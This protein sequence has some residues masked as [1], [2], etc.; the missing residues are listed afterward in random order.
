M[1][2]IACVLALAVVSHGI[3]TVGDWNAWKEEQGKDYNNVDEDLY[4]FGVFQRNVEMIAELNERAQTPGSGLEGVFGLNPLSDLTEAEVR[5]YYLQCL[6]PQTK[7]RKKVHS[8]ELS[9]EIP[10][11]FD[12]RSKGAV[13]PDKDQGQCGS[14][15]AFATVG[16]VEG[17]NF[18]KK[19]GALPNL[20]EQDEVDCSKKQH[21]MGCNGGRVDWGLDYAI[22]AKGL[23]T[24]ASYPY[25]ARDGT[26]KHKPDTVG[27][28]VSKY[29]K[30]KT[31]NETDL[32]SAIA[33]VGPVGVA[34]CVTNAWANY[35]TGVFYDASC[36]SGEFDLSHA[37]LAVGYGT[38]SGKDYFIVKNS[39]GGKWGDGGYIKMARNRNNNCGISTDAYYPTDV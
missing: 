23:D 15:W 35:K 26:C 9:A 6:A 31:K 21:N 37:V 8:A 29:S 38:D 32:A 5:D 24:Q 4:R 28:T 27:G 3:A 12:W 2:V 33:T 39:W 34:I 1:K 7:D 36:K 25:N 17:I 10:T 13:T 20:S 14:C 18:I 16:T 11:D 30:I 19:G 22:A